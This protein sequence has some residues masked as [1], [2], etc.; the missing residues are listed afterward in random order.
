MMRMK[1]IGRGLAAF[2][3]LT[4]LLVQMA[5]A[6]PAQQSN[7]M[8]I[9]L[10]QRAEA[11]RVVFDL[12]GI[13]MYQVKVENNGMRI[14]LDL[15]ATINK[16]ALKD[17]LIQDDVVKSIKFSAAEGNAFRATIDLHRK[18]AYK[19]EPL[20]QPYRLY[21][22]ILK[23][24]DQK[25]VKEIAPGLKHI[26]EVRGGENG[27]ITAHILDVD[28][29]AGYRLRPELARGKVVGRE[30][31]SGIA[32][33]TQALAAV[34]AS[35]FAASGEILGLTKIDHAVVS[36]TYLARSA[37]GILGDGTPIFGQAEYNGS[38][39][40]PD[41]SSLPI[42]GVN[43]E[44]GENGL[45]LYNSHYDAG[46]GSNAYG[47]EYVLK[48]GVVSA[49]Y[50]ANAPLAP[51]T[52]VV[53]AHGASRE[54]L[55]KLKVGDKVRISEELGDPWNRAAHILGVGPMLVK[56]GSVY[57]TTKAEAFGPDVAGGR[58]PR[59]AV[60]VTKDQHVLLVV[61]DGR[62]AHSRGYTLLEMALFMQEHGAVNAVNFDGGGSSEMVVSGKIVNSPSDGNERNIG[63]ALVIL[64]K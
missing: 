27:L 64:P 19:A 23:K 54:K 34:N 41:G 48:D 51:G 50:D 55:A 14:V 10:S 44:R 47:T 9:R 63:S 17:L 15:P 29:K 30:T 52:V 13:P 42:S 60:G 4:L 18:A 33:R 61:V 7:V 26:T 21:I 11:V 56:D 36:T 3:A 2:F 37:F 39:I 59:T 1:C 62:Q 53:S 25:I 38:V 46:T 43:C 8:N 5:F 32:G 22:D 20:N 6:A 12:D 49:I 40:L 58:A 45:V 35:Y 57:L 24:Q 31:L 28:L 16:T